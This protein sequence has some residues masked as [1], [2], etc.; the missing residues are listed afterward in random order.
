MTR[1]VGNLTQTVNDPESG[2]VAISNRLKQQETRNINQSSIRTNSDIISA[3]PRPGGGLEEPRW[4]PRTCSDILDCTARD[5][6]T[7][8]NFYN[9]TNHRA[10]AE[11]RQ[12]IR[13]HLGITI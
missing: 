1:D 8:L 2:L 3:I 12:E 7:Y 13:K 10:L 9:L 5:A 11:K 4:M 6:N